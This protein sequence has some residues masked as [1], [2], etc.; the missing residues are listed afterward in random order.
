MGYLRNRL[1]QV[2]ENAKRLGINIIKTE[3]HDATVFKEEYVKKFDKILLDVP[4][5][6][7]R[8]N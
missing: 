4:L 5:H 8:S 1:K 6:R 2:E 7:V 3:T